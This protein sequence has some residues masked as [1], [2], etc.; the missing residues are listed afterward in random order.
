MVLKKI[1]APVPRAPRTIRKPK[2]R[3]VSG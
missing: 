2:K 1:G 3:K